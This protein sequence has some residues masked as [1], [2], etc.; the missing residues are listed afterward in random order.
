MKQTDTHQNIVNALEFL[1][2]LEK[3]TT[4]PKNIQQKI[5]QSINNL[6]SDEEAKIK[7]SRVIQELI[8]LCEDANIPSFTRTQL[9]N[10]VSL[11]EVV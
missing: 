11:L 7:A 9:Y 2:E 3:D 10:I 1:S 4:L 8:E 5:S 6:N